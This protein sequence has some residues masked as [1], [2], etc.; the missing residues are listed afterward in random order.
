[1]P[2]MV[3]YPRAPL[4]RALALAE[5]VDKLGGEATV[6]SAADH[7]GNKVGGAF[8]SLV[9]AAVKYGLI[10]TSKGRIKTEPLF[11]DLKLAYNEPQKQDAL[12]R[13]FL[14]PPLFASLAARLDGQ[15]IPSHFEKLLIREYDVTPD[16]AGRLVGYFT[17]GARDAG[18][19]G[20]GGAIT[21]LIAGGSSTVAT[22]VGPSSTREFEEEVEADTSV[23]YV[24]GYSVRITGPGIDSRIAIKDEDDVDIVEAMLKKVRRLLKAQKEAE[25]PD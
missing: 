18:I 3:D 17:D 20:A 2:K 13:A 24:R 25:A 19:I 10:S 9:G 6:A 16:V 5:A 1:M 7:L 4:Q 23:A 12:R 22:S 8:M 15:P 11:Q 21:M 14:S